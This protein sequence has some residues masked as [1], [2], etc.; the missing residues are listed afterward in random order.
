MK[1]LRVNIYTPIKQYVKEVELEG[2]ESNETIEMIASD[3][4]F[5]K[6]WY[7]YEIVEVQND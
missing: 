1:V 6:C 2:D 5:D 4:F 3:I 7:D